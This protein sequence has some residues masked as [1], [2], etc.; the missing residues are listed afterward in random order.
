MRI[1]SKPTI[2]II[3]ALNFVRTFLYD[4]LANEETK[5]SDFL[6]WL[7]QAASSPDLA[8]SEFRIVFDG[9]FRKYPPLNNS[10]INIYFSDSDVADDIIIE[11]ASYLK[12]SG[13][14]VVC[15]SSD[16]DLLTELHGYKIKTLR[17]DA[18]YSLCQRVSLY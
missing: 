5:I 2:Y 4:P 10:N 3:D 14:R 9:G 7:A 11:Q 8:R 1:S 18:F 15:V 16:Q 12:Q 17:C 6:L 13:K